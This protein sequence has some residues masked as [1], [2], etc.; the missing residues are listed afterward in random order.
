MQYTPTAV[1]DE[2]LRRRI[3]AAVLGATLTASPG[4]GAAPKKSHQQLVQP[5]KKTVVGQDVRP[6][7][8]RK[9]VKRGTFEKRRKEARKGTKEVKTCDPQAQTCTIGRVKESIRA[10]M[11]RVLEE[12]AAA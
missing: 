2:S 6:W 11:A 10:R 1:Q 3:A 4:P 5:P 7:D 8:Q 9:F 12:V